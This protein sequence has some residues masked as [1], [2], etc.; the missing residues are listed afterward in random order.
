MKRKWKHLFLIGC[1]VCLMAGCGG[2]QAEAAASQPAAVRAESREET[3]EQTAAETTEQTPAETQ[4]ETAA[5]SQENVQAEPKEQA[6]ESQSAQLK[7]VAAM[8]GMKDEETADLFGGGEENWTADKSFYIGRN[9]QVD[10][11]GDTY[12]VFTTCGEDKTVESVSIWIVG[13][14]RQVTD[15]E[16]KEWENRVTDMMGAEPTKDA[17]VSE[18]GSKNTRWTADGMAA[19]MNQM[20]D[21]LTISFQPA[22]GELK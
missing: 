22:L 8:V 21:I 10:L 4:G 6:E 17:G 20:A 13:G 7:D 5:E 15:E 9:Y 1:A 12:K 3:K 16:A 18:G 11:Y 2:H 19:G 14:E